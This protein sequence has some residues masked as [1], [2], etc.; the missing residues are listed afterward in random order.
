MYRTILFVHSLLRWLVLI[1]GA[2]NLLAGLAGV[3]SKRPYVKADR[4]AGLAF[5]ITIDV[6]FLL[7]LA[8]YVALSPLTTLTIFPH[9]G[10]AMKDRVLRFWAVE[11]VTLMVLALTAAHVG[12]VLVKRASDP[13]LKHRR[14]FLWTLLALI[15]LG[16]G[17]PWQILP[18]G[19]ALF[20]W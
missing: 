17:I 13:L 20:P 14:S 12:N 4:V 5:M 2:W 6:Q 3:A 15:L 1:S 18:Y 8:L 7:G 11:H 10:A 16:A 19:R 9:F